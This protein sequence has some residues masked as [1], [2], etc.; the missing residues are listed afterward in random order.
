MIFLLLNHAVGRPK[1]VKHIGL[2]IIGFLA[3]NLITFLQASRGIYLIFGAHID[4]GKVHDFSSDEETIKTIEKEY[5]IS[6][7]EKSEYSEEKLNNIQTTR[8]ETLKKLR[9]TMLQRQN[10]IL[11]RSKIF[12]GHLTKHNFFDFES[13]EGF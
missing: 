9:E 11:R 13:S 1:D 7:K 10:M 2:I 5:E 4:H 6:E 3:I 8:S 12:E